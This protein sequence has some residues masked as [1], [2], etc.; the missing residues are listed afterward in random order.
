MHDLYQESVDALDIV[1]PKLAALGY[2][3][4]TVSQLF[5]ASNQLLLPH[6]VY[7]GISIGS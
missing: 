3:F 2:E 1:L 6:E 7:Y 5:E 4:V